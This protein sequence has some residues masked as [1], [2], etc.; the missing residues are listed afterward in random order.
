MLDFLILILFCWLFFKVILLCLKAAWGLTKIVAT[1]LF[2]LAFPALIA[3]LLFAGGILLM[4]PVGL[5]AGAL[6]LL[7][8]CT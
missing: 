1:I 6:V 2:V 4:V 3:C 5:M 8:T 7:K